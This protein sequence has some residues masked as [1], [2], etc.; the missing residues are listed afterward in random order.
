MSNPLWLARDRSGV[1]A[2][3]QKRRYVNGIFVSTQDGLFAFGLEY[4]DDAGF[5]PKLKVGEQ[6]E[7]RIVPVPK[8]TDLE[9]CG[10]EIFHGPGHQSGSFCDRVG[11]HTQHSLESHGL[12]WS[13]KKAFSGYFDNS[14]EDQGEPRRKKMVRVRR[15]K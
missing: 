3:L 9:K 7:V 8:K 11:P 13:T 4:M 12:Y 6:V 1:S 14:P 2:C 15:L 5:L 10:A